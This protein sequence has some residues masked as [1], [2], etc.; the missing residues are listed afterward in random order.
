MIHIQTFTFN[1]FQENTYVLSD[2]SG[3]CVII[4]PGCY[5]PYEKETIS[6]Y[7]KAKNL[8]P[9]HLLNTHCHIDHILGNRYISDTYNLL[10]VINKNELIIM[11]TAA[12]LGHNWGIQMDESPAPGL[13]LDEGDTVLFGNSELQVLFLPGHSP[14]SIGFL[15]KKEN[16]LISGDVLFRESIGRTDLPGGDLPL[17]L[18]SIRQKLFI[19]DNSIQVHPGHGPSTTIGHEKEKNP[20]LVASFY[21]QN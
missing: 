18:S 6:S 9:V 17:L 3:E 4:D 21:N 13:F 5:S 7:I 19:L 16:I 1:D 12:I 11:Q 8:K 20:F 2:E 15:S 14:G 10:P